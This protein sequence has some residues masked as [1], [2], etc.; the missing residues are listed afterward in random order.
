MVLETKDFSLNG[1]ALDEF[2]A[3]IIAETGGIA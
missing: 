2:Q 3:D 1:S